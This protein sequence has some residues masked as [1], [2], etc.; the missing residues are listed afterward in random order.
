MKLLRTL[1]LDRSDTFVFSKAAE[2]GEWA[3]AGGFMFWDRDP[4][5][6]SGKDRAAFRSGF[7]GV[8]SGGWSTLVEVAEATEE[9]REAAI[10]SLARF[11]VDNLGA[12]DVATARAAAA[13]EIAFAATL[14]EPPPG[15]VVALQRTVEADGEVRE[16]FR[17]LTPTLEPEG[18]TFAQGCVLPIGIARED[19]APEEVDFVGMISASS[20]GA[21]KGTS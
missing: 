2:P 19:G 16:R 12:P 5:S 3:V 20:N 18:N 1:R 14:C 6:L 17:T 15:T 7:L 13:E 10:T 11:L 8:A 9:Q 21:S 4:A